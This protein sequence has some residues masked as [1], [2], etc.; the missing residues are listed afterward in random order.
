M[1]GDGGGLLGFD[2]A[3]AEAAIAEFAPAL[4]QH[5]HFGRESDVF[6]SG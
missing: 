2:E 1:N 3:S 6:R 4:L 5:P